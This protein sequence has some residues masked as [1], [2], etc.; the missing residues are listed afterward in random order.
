M[1]GAAV[2]FVATLLLLP[3]VTAAEPARVYYAHGMLYVKHAI[4]YHRAWLL[5]E[6]PWREFP[7]GRGVRVAVIDTGI[8]P[9]HP[10]LAGT[11]ALWRDFAGDEHGVKRSEPYDDHGHGTHVAGVIA[12]RG[13]FAK[14]PFHAYFL[15]GER[16]I[17]PGVVLYVAKAMRHNGLGSDAAVGAAIAWAADPNGDGSCVDGADVINLSIGVDSVPSLGFRAADDATSRAVKAAIAC[18]VVVV[19]ASGN[20]GVDRVAEPGSIPGVIVVGAT[21]T[22]DDVAE[23]SNGGAAVDVVAPGVTMSAFPYDRDFEDGVVDGYAGLAGTSMAAPVVAA[24]AALLIDADA[25][26]PGKGEAL[27]AHRALRIETLLRE[28]ARPLSS[29]R[30]GAGVVDVGAALALVESSGE[31]SLTGTAIALSLAATLALAGYRSARALTR[32][33]PTRPT[34]RTGST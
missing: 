7:D 4:G 27:S 5:E 20:N 12:G 30:S 14:N 13:H 24:V 15:T 9:T 25:T 2:A 16:G 3:T 23:F 26:L 19:V 28:T 10:D 31:W 18:G 29:P 34:R 17:A 33:P 11:V 6:P 21:E 32:A 1:R 22:L 8:D